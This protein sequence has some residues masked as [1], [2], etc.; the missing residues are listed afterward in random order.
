MHSSEWEVNAPLPND[1]IE[2]LK[3]AHGLGIETWVSLE[4]VVIPSETLEIINLTHDFVD[5]YKVG[6]LNYDS[7][8]KTIDWKEFGLNAI[9]LLEKYNKKYY[10]KDDLKKYL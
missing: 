7:L 3:F 1:R 8:A 2:T 10:I 9:K 4:P 5:F 6:T